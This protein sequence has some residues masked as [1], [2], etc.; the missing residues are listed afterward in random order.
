MWTYT[1]GSS[2]EGYYEDSI[3]LF[4]LLVMS[5]NWWTY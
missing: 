5:G 1:A 2:S 3:K 4:S